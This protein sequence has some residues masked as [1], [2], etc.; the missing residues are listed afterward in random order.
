MRDPLK[1]I[2]QELEAEVAD[3]ENNIKDLK[4]KLAR[5]KNSNIIRVFSTL[6]YI[7]IMVGE[8]VFLMSNDPEDDRE[9]KQFPE[10]TYVGKQILYTVLPE[11]VQ[12]VIIKRCEE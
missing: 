6:R 9:L 11:E 7:V 8:L 4:M 2:V 1:E 5:K 3:M 12:E 10:D